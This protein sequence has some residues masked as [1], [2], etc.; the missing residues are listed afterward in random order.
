MKNYRLRK[1]PKKLEFIFLSTGIG[2]VI[3]MVFSILS[4]NMLLNWAP[5]LEQVLSLVAALGLPLLWILQSIG[6]YLSWNAQ[7]I[8]ISEDAIKVSKK[9]GWMGQS[10]TVYRYESIVSAELQQTH[11][12]QKYGYGDIILT[13]P[14]LEN[15]VVLGNIDLPTKSMD[16]IQKRIAGLR[17]NTQS[18]INWDASIEKYTA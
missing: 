15:D 17:Q 13:I 8:T 3:L 6:L 5:R 7:T 2:T 14:K 12:G 1:S 4:I 10:N 9:R 18:L 11:F 16:Y